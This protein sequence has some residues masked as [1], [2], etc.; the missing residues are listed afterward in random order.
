MV[1]AVLVQHCTGT[2]DDEATGH[3]AKV[4]EDVYSGPCR[5]QQRDQHAALTNSAGGT[6]SVQST[7]LHLP[8]I[9]SGAVKPDVV[10][11]TDPAAIKE[12]LWRAVA[13]VCVNDP[14]RE[15][16]VRPIVADMTK[17]DATARRLLCAE[18]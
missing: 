12:S 6:V 10:D 7:E 11:M 14:A 15:G 17:T 1:D 4:W 5:W 8:V 13:T 16:V 18:V 2:V 9:A 3:K